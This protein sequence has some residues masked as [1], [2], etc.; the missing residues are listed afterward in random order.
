[1]AYMDNIESLEVSWCQYY[2]LD[3]LSNKVLY[4]SNCRH[5][6]WGHWPVNAHNFADSGEICSGS[7]SE[8]WYLHWFWHGK[9]RTTGLNHV[10]L[11]YQ[12]S[13]YNHQ[14]CRPWFLT[15]PKGH[16]KKPM[17][18]P[19]IEILRKMT[20]R[21]VNFD[22]DFLSRYR[23]YKLPTKNGHIIILWNSNVFK[24]FVIS[25]QTQLT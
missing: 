11:A 2:A 25:P 10:R 19:N 4:I 20:W 17:F 24:C 6:W 13:L 7:Q 3:P 9:S 16:G 1:M 14:I 12:V 23:C 5:V 21:P 22:F 8:T 15:S 18:Y